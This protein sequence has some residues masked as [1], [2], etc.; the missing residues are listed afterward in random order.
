MA[1][2]IKMKQRKKTRNTEKPFAA[3]AYLPKLF[4]MIFGRFSDLSRFG[5]L[6][7]DKKRQ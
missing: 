5:R 3:K 7:I 1:F 2:V 4:T 6:P